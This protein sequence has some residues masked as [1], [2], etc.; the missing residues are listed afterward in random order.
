MAIKKIAPEIMAAL[1]D[2]IG[3][4]EEGELSE[5]AFLDGMSGTGI[6]LECGATRDGV[7]PDAE[8]YEC[9]VCEAH[10]VMGVEQAIM[11]YL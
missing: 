7:E 10:A 4:G 8:G 11:T 6:C 9:E 5:S 2:L 3:E 1:E